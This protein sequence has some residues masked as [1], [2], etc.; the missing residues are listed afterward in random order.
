[1]DQTE[2]PVK[3]PPEFSVYAEKHHIFEVFQ[4]DKL[5][6]YCNYDPEHLIH[7]ES[8]SKCYHRF[9]Q[10]LTA[11]I[12]KKPVDPLPFIDEY[13]KRITEES[14]SELMK[15]FINRCLTFFSNG[16]S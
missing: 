14:L 11:L 1:M 3:I 2:R 9:Q 16:F 6:Y 8:W 4:V 7:S 15:F 12:I 13:L 5:W 10:I